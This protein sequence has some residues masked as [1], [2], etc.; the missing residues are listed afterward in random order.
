LQLELA[1]ARRTG[2]GGRYSTP[3]AAAGEKQIHH[4]NRKT[5]LGY[6]VVLDGRNERF[7]EKLLAETHPA[8][9]VVEKLIDVRPVV[10]T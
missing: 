7:G 8:H 1:R 5:H 10:K 3:Y 4:Y 6:L 2:S 9:T